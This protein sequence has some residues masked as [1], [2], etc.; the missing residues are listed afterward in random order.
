MS[1][2]TSQE[3]ELLLTHD[4]QYRKLYYSKWLLIIICLILL[5]GTIL[6]VIYVIVFASSQQSQSAGMFG[7]FPCFG[8]NIQNQQ[9]SP[10]FS[11]NAINNTTIKH[12][13]K[14]CMYE[15]EG[16]NSFVGYIT[17]D[18]NNNGYVTGSGSG[19]VACINL[20]T[21][22]EKWK[23]NLAPIILGENV[24]NSFNETYQKQYLIVNTRHSVTLYRDSK[25]I[26]S[27]LIGAPSGYGYDWHPL[28]NYSAFAISLRAD[29]GKL[30]WKLYLGK[31]RPVSFMVESHFAYGGLTVF[32][33]QVFIGR[34]VKIDLD[35]AHIVHE[36]YAIPPSMI[37]INSNYTYK[38]I[39]IWSYPAI[40][41]DFVLFGTGNLHGYPKYI[42]NC[43]LGN[44]SALPLNRSFLLNPCGE[45]QPNNKWWRCLEKDIYADSIVVLNK[46]TF[47]LEFAIPLNGVDLYLGYC[48]DS[49]PNNVFCP[50][51]IGFDSDL[52]AVAA[53]H[54]NLDGEYYAALLDK[55]GQFYVFQIPSGK[56]MISKK[57]GPWS[58]AG[59]GQWSIAVDPD[60][61]IAILTITGG[62]LPAYKQVLA[63]GVT[64]TCWRTGTVHAIDLSNGKLLWQSVNP[65]G[66]IN[67]C[68]GFEEYVDKTMNNTCEYNIYSNNS[69]AE[70]FNVNIV[71]PELDE[72][73][74]EMLP[75][76]VFPR[77]A[78]YVAP[79]T[80]SN[81]MVFVPSFTG[82]ILIHDLF[83][84]EYIHKLQ[85]PNHLVTGINGSLIWNRYGIKGGVS[86][87]DERIV[88]FCG[89]SLGG[90]STMA[91]NQI[92]SMKL[93]I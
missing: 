7:T 31:G 89:A 22:T 25:G 16:A 52:A 4:T 67:N 14:T 50:K 41:G 58:Y 33:Q 43:L 69:N 65:F 21:C 85:C 79:V 73:D 80:I 57:I 35:N 40:I 6:L 48:V 71:I 75:M 39:S 12:V 86:V 45:L 10:S 51:V 9:I 74:V 87:V 8:G 15:L 24:Y 1:T 61:M 90:P 20:D 53:Y 55:S 68:S 83:S 2:G 47:D 59:G 18:D 93:E 38:G 17:I 30:L 23:V 44:F 76:D 64:T 13:N 32:D 54:S 19:H 63:D 66:S 42:E 91:G 3:V 77:R 92:I 34:F 60:A 27:V 46:H 84:G 5:L 82:D 72:Y 62:S 29:T 81:N 78:R 49:N 56:L 36:W 70:L 28:F 37:D 88:F 26:K 11:S